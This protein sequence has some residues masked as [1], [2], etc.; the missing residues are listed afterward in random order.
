M[1]PA[2]TTV[3]V[4]T[5]GGR[6]V[7]FVITWQSHGFYSEG[8]NGFGTDDTYSD[9]RLSDIDLYVFDRN[10]VQ[11]DASAS[12]DWTTEWVEWTY[13]ATRGPYSVRISPYSWSCSLAQEKIG[14]AWV[15]WSA[16]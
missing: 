12:V 16:P 9:A 5:G 11:V 3:S 1:K 4:S 8:A 2:P 14:W 10:G 13:D 7:R 15:A 6:K